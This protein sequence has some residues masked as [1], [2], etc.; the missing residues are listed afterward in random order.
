M[1]WK[2]FRLR[3]PDGTYEW[4]KALSLEDIIDK[5]DLWR[6]ENQDIFVTELS[7]EM[8]AIAISNEMDE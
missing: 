8:R 1:D 4:T 7:G 2:Y 3:Y 6:D 5:Y